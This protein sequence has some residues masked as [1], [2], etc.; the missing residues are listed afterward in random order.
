MVGN[1]LL[2][3]T[4]VSGV[5]ELRGTGEKHREFCWWGKGTSGLEDNTEDSQHTQTVGSLHPQCDVTSALS[6]PSKGAV[7]SHVIGVAS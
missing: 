3:V 4:S 2:D 5:T 6:I 1:E 7:Y